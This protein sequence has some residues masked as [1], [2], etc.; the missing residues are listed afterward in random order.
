MTRQRLHSALVIL[1]MLATTYA[2]KLHYSGA[3]A[4]TLQWILAP[5]AWLVETVF[6]APFGFEQHVGYV[7][8]ELRFAI[9]P[10][11]A[12]INFMII[13]ICTATLGFVGQM[14]TFSAKLGLLFASV[15]LAYV[16]A[17]A[18]NSARI[19]VALLLQVYPISIPGFSPSQ[20]HH[21]Q[22]VIVYFT[23]LCF[24]YLLADRTLSRE[25]AL[26]SK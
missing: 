2:L 8:Q 20:V 4:E 23:S 16:A 5:T 18:V 15:A 11:C 9:V 19:V 26:I 6:R 25:I 3:T 12:G 13:V 1:A 17:L 7:N 21:A 24:L 10:S 14:R 22:G